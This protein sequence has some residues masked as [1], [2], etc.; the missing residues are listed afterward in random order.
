[1]LAGACVNR[2]AISNYVHHKQGERELFC[3]CQSVARFCQESPPALAAGTSNL[4]L[5]FEFV[6]FDEIAA[7]LSQLASIFKNVCVREQHHIL[8]MA[9]GI[10]WWEGSSM[11]GL[12][13]AVKFDYFLKPPFSEFETFAELENCT[14]LVL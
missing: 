1:M 9:S 2:F 11:L 8:L 3:G 5:K 10:N 7:H 6:C 13:R 12:G 14:S 4:T